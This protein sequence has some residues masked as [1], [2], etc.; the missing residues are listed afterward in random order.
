MKIK[1][2]FFLTLLTIFCGCNNYG[3]LVHLADLPRTLEENSGIVS[4]K[5]ATLWVIEDNGNKDE[6]YKLNFKGDIVKSFKVKNAKNRDWEDLTKDS[7]N[8]VYIADIGNNNNDRKDLVIYKVSN[9]EKQLGNKI[10]AEKI[11]FYYPEQKKFPPKKSDRLY[12]AEAIF[13]KNNK[14]YII[15]KN[16]TNP[17]NGKALIYTVPDSKGSYAAKLVGT[18]NVCHDWKTCQITAIDI[19]PD[20]KK[21]VALSY[22]KLFL[23]TDF[24]LDDFTTGKVHVIDLEIRN[25]LESVCFLNANTLLLSDEVS[26]GTGGNLYRYSLPN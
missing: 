16:R 19:S 1:A 4:L 6:L 17:F 25:Q 23:Y 14:L 10:V 11:E 5:D 22:G 9:P 7:L 13:H 3:Q 20:G 15:T 24:S 21:I 12:D 18:I 8:N 2:F 26:H